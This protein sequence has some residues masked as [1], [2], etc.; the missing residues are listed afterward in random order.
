M[1]KFKNVKIIVCDVDGVLTDGRLILNRDEEFKVWSVHDRYGITLLRKSGL[2]IKLAWISGRYSKEVEFRAKEIGIDEVVQNKLNKIE[3][4]ENILKKY[5]IKP[6]EA[7]YIGDDLVDIPPM[8][9]C[10]GVAPA[11]AHPLVKK[12]AKYIVKKKSG[13]GVLRDVIE[14][15]LK[16]NG[17]FKKAFENSINS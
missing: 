16:D 3:A 2:D 10:I 1:F 13:E 6:L 14:K 17:V 4:L 5:S 9:R 12:Y 8:K 7:I 11:N 15:I